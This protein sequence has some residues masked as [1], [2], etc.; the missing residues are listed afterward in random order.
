MADATAIVATKIVDG[1]TDDQASVSAA[2][3]LLVDIAN[4]S[5]ATITID[6]EFG[7][8]ASLTDNFANP[9]VV[10]VGAFTMV[11]DGSTWDRA[12][13]TSTD[14][15][16]VNLG[17][18][19]DVTVTGTVTVDSELT[20]G[21]LDTGA[22][23]DTRAVVGLV[24]SASGGGQLIPGSATDGLLVNLGGN[25][26]VTVTSGSITADTEL[27][28]ADLDTGG[29]T[30]T[31]AVVGLVGAKSGGGVL[32]PGDATAGLKVDLG[33]DNDVTVTG[34][35]TADT[36]LPSAASLTDNF[37]NPTAPAVGAF[38]MVWDGSTW[39]R[40]PGNSTD[41][42]LVEVSNPGGDS[43]PTG[44]V[45]EYAAT[46]ALAAGASDAVD[47]SEAAGKSLSMLEVWSS[48]PYKATL[49]T[50]DNDVESA[51]KAIGGGQAAQPWSFKPP[52]K[53][54]FTLGTTAG[55]DNFRVNVTNLDNSQ[56]ADCH[57][58]FHYEG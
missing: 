22:G 41:G 24:G 9:T 32:I 35:V 38:G 13:G 52:H 16:L 25:N 11:F 30:D 34:S 56:A 42:L 46:T 26:D 15:L 12:P 17:G 19:N 10:G 51:E 53:A 37:A 7:A 54:Y 58:V 27:T 36:E 29:G 50:V 18:N 47:S 33:A 44:P 3:H 55:A 4:V 39:D 43:T 45:N 1:S 40:A 28:T 8:A 49:H 21:D 57:V 20:T 31:R 14:G 48:V 5:D 23:T 6:T 2:G